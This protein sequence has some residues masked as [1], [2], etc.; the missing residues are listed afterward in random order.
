MISI[1]FKFSFLKDTEQGLLATKW[2]GE[3]P[4]EQGVTTTLGALSVPWLDVLLFPQTKWKSNRERMIKGK[5][6]QVQ[7]HDVSRLGCLYIMNPCSSCKGAG[8]NRYLCPWALGDIYTIHHIYS[9]AVGRSQITGRALLKSC[10]VITVPQCAHVTDE[11][12]EKWGHSPNN[13]QLTKGR[14]GI[15]FGDCHAPGTLAFLV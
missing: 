10:F 6:P 3:R 9:G 5:K 7:S 11:K 4:P 13:T 12:S 2:L 14:A 15:G 8:S 1:R